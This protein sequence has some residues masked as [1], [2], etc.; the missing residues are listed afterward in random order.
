MTYKSDD[1]VWEFEVD[2]LK[3]LIRLVRYHGDEKKVTVSEFFD[4]IGANAFYGTSITEIF[5]E[6][7]DIILE[8]SAF[9]GSNIERISLPKKMKRIE[10]NTF[11]GSSKLKNIKVPE[12]L[13]YI[14]KSAFESCEALSCVILPDSLQIIDNRAFSRSGLVTLSIPQ[15]TTLIGDHAFDHCQKLRSTDIKG[16]KYIGEAAFAECYNL[17]KVNLPESLLSIGHYAFIKN[18]KLKQLVLPDSLLDIGELAFAGIKYMKVSSPS[19]L[20][21]HIKY[22]FREDSLNNNTTTVFF[23]PEPLNTIFDKTA[24]ITFR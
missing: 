15:N 11:A 16:A 12:G 4:S 23:D 18:A 19:S 22:F 13:Q 1:N 3:W 5:F 7:D 6:N 17:E 21:N 2:H 9:R 14:G 10:N 20:E 24:H 8:E